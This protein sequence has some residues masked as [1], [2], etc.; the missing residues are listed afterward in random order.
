MKLTEE[1]FN[2]WKRLKRE[3]KEAS[4]RVYS[5]KNEK[6]ESE[7]DTAIKNLCDFE[8]AHNIPMM[9]TEED[10]KPMTN[11]ERSNGLSTEEK[12]KVL[13]RIC[14]G[15]ADDCDKGKTGKLYAPYWRRWLREEYRGNDFK[16]N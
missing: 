16:I 11:E 5:T 6:T 10:L 12:A 7:F 3:A 4:H 8:T 14:V 9:A 13:A 1:E 15:A 2:E